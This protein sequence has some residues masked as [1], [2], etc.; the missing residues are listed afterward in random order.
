MKKLLLFTV[1]LLSIASLVGCHK[2]N[3]TSSDNSSN[4]PS[5][6]ISDNTS[7]TD[8]TSDSSGS[9]G[10]SSMS[11]YENYRE[12][13]TK[14]ATSHTVTFYA[15]LPGD[16][17][18]YRTHYVENNEKIK[19]F[20]CVMSGYNSSTWFYDRY[21]TQPFDFDTPI[22]SD[23]NL[24]GYPGFRN[25]S[26]NITDYYEEG[27]FDIKW[28]NCAGCSYTLADGGTLPS[29]ANNGDEINF[30]ITYSIFATDTAKVNVND[31]EVKAN[32]DGIYT[33]KISNNTT[34][35][36]TLEGGGTIIDPKPDPGKAETYTVTDLPSWIQSDG[37]VIFAWVWGNTN[38]GEWL[39]TKY[40]GDTTLTFTT[41]G[42]ITGMLLAR[43]VAGTE[44]PNWDLHDPSND[45][46]RVY[47]QTED[48][49]IASGVTT[50]SCS[51][52]KEYH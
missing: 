15:N 49:A 38:P 5:D 50:Y 41:N 10:S 25:S 39:A 24:Y 44:T 47:N 8:N 42:E 19:I 34:I 14:T 12:E 22:T 46:G 7:N 21:G 20:R 13:G 29:K 18:L 27:D 36:A 51:S 52:W 30:K 28:V 31:T 35:T 23:L 43:C 45:P 40:T 26:P 16:D 2:G 17:C 48:I 9:T 33:I 1:S 6:Q 4:S 3:K 11:K 37:C 32:D